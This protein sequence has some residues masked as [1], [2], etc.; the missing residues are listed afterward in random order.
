MKK[1][2]RLKTSVDRLFARINGKKAIQMANE[3]TNLVGLS[4]RLCYAFSDDQILLKALKHRSYL[5][6]SGE[7]RIQS[8]ERLELL[9]DAVLGLI[10]TE[11]LYQ[12]YP[13]K[14][15]GDLTTL[16]SVLVSR[17]SLSKIGRELGL[18]QYMLLSVAESKSG[19]RKRASILADAIEALIGAIYLDGGLAEAEQFVQKNIISRLDELQA[20][21][22][23]KNYKSILLEYCQSVSWD[24]PVYVVDDETGPDHDKTFTVAAIVN[25][26]KKGY[27]VGHTKKLAEQ[28]A[29]KQV[30]R[31]AN[32][33]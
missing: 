29:A 1:T 30:L 22:V 14:E 9:G 10:V 17:K 28:Q 3:D 7:S 18:G 4:K 6:V 23:M 13:N 16:K 26:E 27:G 32:L 21:G 15:E 12:A 8:N 19:G 2:T 11:F 25:G 24:G 20:D 33:L 5:T 31:N